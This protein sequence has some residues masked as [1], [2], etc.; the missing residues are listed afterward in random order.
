[1]L[2]KV[3]KILPEHR[4]VVTEVKK[5]MITSIPLR[6]FQQ[7]EDIAMLAVFLASDNARNINGESINLDGGMVRD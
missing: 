5:G 6:R 2:A 3:E 7:P 4:P 1:M